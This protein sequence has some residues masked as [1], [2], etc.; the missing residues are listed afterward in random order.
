MPGSPAARTPIDQFAQSLALGM[1]PLGR[2]FSYFAVAPIPDEDLREYLHEPI[3]AL[4][5]LVC[6]AIAPI[7]VILVPYLERE[8]PNAIPVVAY[9][10]PAAKRLIRSAYLLNDGNTLFFSVREEHPSDY[11]QFFF[12]TLAHLLSRH[13]TPRL[14]QEYVDLLAKEFEEQVHGEVDEPSWR[15]KQALPR[16]S[17]GHS[18]NLKSR[19]FR[20]Y[21]TQSFVDTMTLYLHGICCDIDVERGPRQM[22]SRWLRKRLEAL[23]KMFPPPEGRAVFPEQLGG[24]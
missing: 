7:K 4:P 3:A 23:Y 14:Q 21:A 16:R 5:S 11:H 10:T 2:G 8:S 9:D 20:D 22:P 13:L 24:R 12:N 19:S 18:P 6:D 15:A 1:V 17:N